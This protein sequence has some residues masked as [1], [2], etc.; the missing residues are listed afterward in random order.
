MASGTQEV[1]YGSRVVDEVKKRLK[2]TG[3]VVKAQ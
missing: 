3:A 2:V 1:I